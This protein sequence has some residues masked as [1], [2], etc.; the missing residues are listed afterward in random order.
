MRTSGPV[1]F[2]AAQQT[3]QAFLLSKTHLPCAQRLELR[4]T[5]SDHPRSAAS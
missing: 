1:I 2:M 5:R 4:K 3:W